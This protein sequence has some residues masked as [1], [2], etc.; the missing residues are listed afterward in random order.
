MRVPVRSKSTTPSREE[1]R[2][3]ADFRL[4]L[5]RFHAATERVVRSSELTYRQYLLLLVLESS[6]LRKPTTVGDLSE[7][8]GLAPST[9]TELLDRAE[10]AGLLERTHAAHDG[11]VFHVRATREGRK[12]LA[13]AFRELADER[14]AVAGTA[15]TLLE[16]AEASA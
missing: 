15:L 2:R 14:R 13:K 4:A 12:R 7:A 6:L 1:L 3:A 16:D 8:L 10:H 5:R 9:M 11:R